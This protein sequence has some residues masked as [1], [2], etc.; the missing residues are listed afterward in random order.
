MSD[1]KTEKLNTGDVFYIP[2]FV[3]H[4]FDTEEECLNIIAFHPDNDWGPTDEIHPMI[5]RTII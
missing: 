3:K 1:A 5:N 2:P 4:M